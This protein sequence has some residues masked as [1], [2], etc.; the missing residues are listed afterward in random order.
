MFDKNHLGHNLIEHEYTPNKYNCKKCDIIVS[1]DDGLKYSYF[2][3]NK[4]S[5]YMPLVLTCNEM[6][7]KEL[8][9]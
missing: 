9:E 3:K 6:V 2:I 8:L 5:Y 1:F 7:I 4:K